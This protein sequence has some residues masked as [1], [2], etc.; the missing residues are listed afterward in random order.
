MGKTSLYLPDDLVQRARQVGIVLSEVARRALE[1]AVE[2]RTR[3]CGR[4]GAPLPPYDEDED[5]DEAR[6][7]ATS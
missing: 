3:H 4:C 7:W 1:E 5:D 2:D 6:S